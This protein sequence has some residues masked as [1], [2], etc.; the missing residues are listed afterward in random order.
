MKK[1]FSIIVILTIFSVLSSPCLAE[2]QVEIKDN[3][4]VVLT[5]SGK[6]YVGHG[7]TFFGQWVTLHN[8][9]YPEKYK[10]LGMDD[11]VAFPMDQVIN[12]Y[13]QTRPRH[14]FDG[15]SHTHLE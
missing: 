2:T 4:D 9:R 3:E 5:T 7:V 14:L 6:V 8:V 10:I 11:D 1:L 13:L 12:I 15:N